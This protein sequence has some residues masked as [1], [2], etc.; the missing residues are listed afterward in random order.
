MYVY[1]CE[2]Q[3]VLAQV[4]TVLIWELRNAVGEPAGLGSRQVYIGFG[5]SVGGW[6]IKI[7]VLAIINDIRIRVCVLGGAWFRHQLVSFFKLRNISNNK[8]HFLHACVWW[9][10][11]WWWRKTDCKKSDFDHQRLQNYLEMYELNVIC[12]RATMD[13]GTF[14]FPAITT[15]IQ[16]SC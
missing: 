5:H 15:P 11:C 14:T 3:L 13:A 12:Q 8:N 2:D 1:L 9:A 4:R 16:R 7:G 6:G 10:S